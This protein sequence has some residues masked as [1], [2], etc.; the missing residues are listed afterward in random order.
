MIKPLMIEMGFQNK[1]LFI[2]SINNNSVL[3]KRNIIQT[4]LFNKKVHKN[5]NTNKCGE[6][7]FFVYNLQYS[8]NI[9][10]TP[11]LRQLNAC[12]ERLRSI[13]C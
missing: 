13:K 10:L 2:E 3:K 5:N 12:N 6:N 11:V 8:T 7:N 1:E 9:L 4:L